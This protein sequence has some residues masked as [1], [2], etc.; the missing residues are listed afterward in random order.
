MQR[1]IVLRLQNLLE[2]VHLNTNLQPSLPDSDSLDMGWGPEIGILITTP[3][4]LDAHWRNTDKESG[5]AEMASGIL[6]LV[7]ERA[8]YIS[9]QSMSWMKVRK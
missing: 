5:F 7:T 3:G 6:G 1:A 4:D 2:R 9:S 8:G